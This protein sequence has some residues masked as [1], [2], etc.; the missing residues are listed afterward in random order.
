MKTEDTLDN[1]DGQNT[2]DAGDYE[3]FANY[4]VKFIQNY[5]AEGVPITAIAPQNEP[6][7]GQGGATAYPGMDFP[8]SDEAQFITQNLAPALQTAGLQ[9][10]DLRQRSELELRRL[11]Q[12]TRLRAGGRRSGGDLLA[13]LLRLANCDDPAACGHAR[14][15]TSSSTSAPPRSGGSGPQSS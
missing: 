3:T 14:A 10:E 13:L 12:R 6:S 8:E 9:P 4:I 7:S 1:P 11:R 5:E 2:L 15:W